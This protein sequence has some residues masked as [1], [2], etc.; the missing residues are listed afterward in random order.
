MTAAF[1]RTAD[2][3]GLVEGAADLGFTPLEIVT[4]A[5]YIQAEA[6]NPEDFPKI[7]RAVYNRLEDGQPLQLDSTVNYAT[8]KHD[9]FTSDSDRAS[10]SP[11]NTYRV[12]G[13]TPGPIASPGKEALAAALAPADGPWRYWVTVNL[14]TGETKFSESYEE[15]LRNVEELRAWV[16]ANG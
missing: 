15:H 16:A 3:V 11:Y 10:D 9:I 2:E 13:L 5:S 1:T 4:V 12:S 14:D 7:A 8:G 6:S